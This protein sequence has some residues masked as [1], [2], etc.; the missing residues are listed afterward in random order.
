MQ[1]LIFM[2]AF[3]S[4]SFLDALLMGCTCHF[5]LKWDISWDKQAYKSKSKI[6]YISDHVVHNKSHARI[7]NR[8]PAIYQAL[9]AGGS[10]PETVAL[11]MNTRGH[12]LVF[13]ERHKFSFFFFCLD[14]FP[15]SVFCHY[16]KA[17]W[18][19]FL[20]I[21]QTLKYYKFSCYTLSKANQLY[22]PRFHSVLL[23]HEFLTCERN[24]QPV[25]IE[26]WLML[27]KCNCCCDEETD[28]RFV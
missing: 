26:R 28:F 16:A 11:L 4:H 10:D 14:Y 2:E 12:G 17:T 1:W 6:Y 9:C 27:E 21:M 5:V 8:V 15:F 18:H 22:F 25:F 3:K 24:L 23:I 20:F 7:P 19:K 13:W